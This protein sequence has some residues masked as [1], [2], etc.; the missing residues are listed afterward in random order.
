MMQQYL[1]QCFVVFCNKLHTFEQKATAFMG[2]PEFQV[3]MKCVPGILRKQ[4]P[5]NYRLVNLAWQDHE[6]NP[7]GNHA[8]AH[9]K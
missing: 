3:D 9:R 5:W 6:V 1:S 7:A 4:D 2:F 8:E